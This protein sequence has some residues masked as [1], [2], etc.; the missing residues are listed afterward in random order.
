MFSDSIVKHYRIH[1][2][3]LMPENIFGKS[4]QSDLETESE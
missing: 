1:H 2:Y 3:K 4:V